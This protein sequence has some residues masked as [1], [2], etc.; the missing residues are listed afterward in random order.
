MQLVCR[1][2][3]PSTMQRDSAAQT[4]ETARL[5]GSIALQDSEISEQETAALNGGKV[6]PT[7]AY[8]A[9]EPAQIAGTNQPGK[10]TPKLTAS[11]NHAL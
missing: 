6:T 3:P 2:G 7:P 8:L 10:Q 5:A 1:G 4:T 9:E 11:E